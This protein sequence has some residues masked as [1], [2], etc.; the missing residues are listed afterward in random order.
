M[1]R[2]NQITRQWRILRL[3]EGANKGLR[4][5]EIYERL[6]EQVSERTLFRDLQDLSTAGFPLYKEDDEHWRCLTVGEG[7]YSIPI[8]TS[9]LLAL[10]LSEELLAPMRSAEVVTALAS[11]R[12]KITTLL[13]PAGQA[14]AEELKGHLIATFVGP[15]DYG[16]S[17][18][19]R[20]IEDA[21]AR[22]HRVEIHYWSP[23]QPDDPGTKQFRDTFDLGRH[24]VRI[25]D[26]N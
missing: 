23:K 25:V 19:V 12:E 10:L 1:A 21:I 9:E 3:L 14:Y 15:G 13:T 7:G 20:T 8:Q 24:G 5:R 18:I 17:D 26:A 6:D 4:A 2:G 22:Q 11:L 16:D